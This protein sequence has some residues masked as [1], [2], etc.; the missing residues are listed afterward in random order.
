[1][2]NNG[3]QNLSRPE[4]TVKPQFSLDAQS[5]TIITLVYG[6]GDFVILFSTSL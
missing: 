1:M 2:F 3:E 6:A 4:L 5:L